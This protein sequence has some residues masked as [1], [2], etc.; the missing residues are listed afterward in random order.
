MLFRSS[1]LVLPL[2]AGWLISA[3]IP[4][5]ATAWPAWRAASRPPVE[6]LQGA[7]I[8][9]GGRL[10]LRTRR[11]AGL[12]ALG[13]RLVTAR[14][15][16]L[17]ATVLTLGAS[18]AFVLLLLAL[19]SALSALETDPAAL[20]KRYQLTASLPRCSPVPEP[21]RSRWR[22]SGGSSSRRE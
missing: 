18:T 16:R 15:G 4:V 5:L 10:R 19:A 17:A 9:A 14:R 2:A 8:D 13:A 7:G 21:A 22:T 1:G 6:L 12:T 20:G 11:R 3:S